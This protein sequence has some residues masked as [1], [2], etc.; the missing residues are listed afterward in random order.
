MTVRTSATAAAVILTATIA[1]CSAPAT[2]NNDV[3]LPPVNPQAASLKAGF[4]TMERL[5]ET[6][7]KRARSP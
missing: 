6:A 3:K 4:S 2:E 7:R 1:G 5:V